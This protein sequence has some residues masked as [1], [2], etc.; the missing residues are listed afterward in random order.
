VDTGDPE[1]DRMLTG[2]IQ[3]ITGYRNRSVQPVRSN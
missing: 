1:V 3:V 2:Y